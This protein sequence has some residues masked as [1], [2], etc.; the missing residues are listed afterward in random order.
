MCWK[1]SLLLTCHVLRL[2]FKTLAADDKY[3]FLNRDNLAIPIQMQLSWKQKNCSRIFSA[4]LKSVLNF[5]NFEKKDDPHRFCISQIM[6]SEN[7]VRYMS[8]KSFFRGPFEEQHG[9]L[10]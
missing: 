4:F 6:E 8:E 5:K 10:V 3:P 1:K 2:L 7:V 9:K